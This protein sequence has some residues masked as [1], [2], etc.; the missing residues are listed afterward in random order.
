M[1]VEFMFTIGEST[2]FSKERT[3]SLDIIP[4]D[5]LCKNSTVLLYNKEEY[6]I[7]WGIPVM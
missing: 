6:N 3:P 4:F 1:F 7:E 2:A 5:T